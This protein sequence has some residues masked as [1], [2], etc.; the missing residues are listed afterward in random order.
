MRSLKAFTGVS[1][2]GMLLMPS[3]LLAQTVSETVWIPM[4]DDGFFG[5]KE[6]KLEAT[7]HKPS[8]PGPF[9]VIVFNHGSSGG[10]IPAN[11]TETAKAFGAFLN[12]KGISLLIPM[13]R[14]RGKSEGSNKEEPSPCTVEAAKQG[15]RYASVALDAVFDYVRRQPW[16]ST[17]NIVLAGHS[18]GGI[19]STIYAAEHPT[20]A[21]GV[22]NFAG[23]WKNDNCG[24]TDIN[25]VL[26]EEAARK[27][28][29]P[30]LFIYGRGDGFYSDASAERYEAAFKANGGDV[31][32]KL[33][34]LDRING[35]AIFHK[36]QPVWEKDVDAFIS[37]LGVVKDAK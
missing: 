27:S 23:G 19:L 35:H 14:G 16:A 9:P 7:L 33:Y 1:C 20:L 17:G 12:A 29:V 31:Q 32:F 6:I 36:A 8:G 11:Y 18:R 21:K 26:F 28:K 2:I 25:L 37:K 13:R 24:A 30:N 15:I 5:P 22:I 4:R 3:L 34:A 10:P